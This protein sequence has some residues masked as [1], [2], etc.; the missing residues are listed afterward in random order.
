MQVYFVEEG[1][2]LADTIAAWLVVIGMCSFMGAASIE[3]VRLII[4][5]LR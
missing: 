2:L 1:I 4:A 3:V 5:L